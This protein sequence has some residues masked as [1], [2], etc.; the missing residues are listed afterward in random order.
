MSE[1]IVAQTTRRIAM[2]AKSEFSVLGL[3]TK[4]FRRAES[5]GFD[6]KT[7]N[8]LAESRQLLRQIRLVQAGLGVIN[9]Y[10]DDIVDC[11]LPP[12]LQEWG[13]AKLLR[14][15]T[16]KPFCW[17][18]YGKD[19][20]CIEGIGPG[21]CIGFDLTLSYR[22]RWPMNLNSAVFFAKNYWFI[23]KSWHGLSILFLGTV[24]DIR[25]GDE[26]ISVIYPHEESCGIDML[27]LKQRLDP[28]K[29]RVAVFTR[30]SGPGFASI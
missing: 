22:E 4:L 2:A 20:V 13:N 10:P 27:S 29:C 17:A 30:I 16:Y 25:H 5:A 11:D 8:A 28:E 7:I 21:S 6:S 3:A 1:R 14:N 26:H 12:D 19:I 23:P 18:A 15:I 24:L 9:I